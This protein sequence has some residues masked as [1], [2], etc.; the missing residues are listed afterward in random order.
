MRLHRSEFEAAIRPQVEETVDALRNA[1]ASAGLVPAQ[2]SA[3]LLV[4]G[5]SRI[6]LVG[7]L[8][9]EQLGRPVAV[10]A[11]PKNAIAMGAVLSLTQMGTSGNGPMAPQV[12]APR[13]GGSA[14]F[15]VTAAAPPFGAAPFGT[16]AGAQMSSGMP[17]VPGQQGGVGYGPSATGT[18]RPGTYDSGPTSVAAPPT[19]RLGGASGARAGVLPPPPPPRPGYG[20]PEYGGDPYEYDHVPKPA[21]GGRSPALA[22][23]RRGRRGGG[24]RDRR[25]VP[26]A[27]ELAGAGRRGHTAG[28]PGSPVA[29]GAATEPGLDGRSVRPGDDAGEP[30]G[31]RAAHAAGGPAGDHGPAADHDTAACGHDDPADGDHDRLHRRRRPYPH[32][33]ADATAARRRSRQCSSKARLPRVRASPPSPRRSDS[34]PRTPVPLDA[35]PA[36]F[37]LRVVSADTKNPVPANR[38]GIS[39]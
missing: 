32:A 34:P 14:R 6:P 11:D 21:R 31:T 7:Q 37:V 38:N 22:G 36:F 26:V 18:H 23:E 39:L 24:G 19:Q 2:L 9:S 20:E 4:G 35:V 5:S 13:V 12:P 8:V 28:Q 29:G 15:P 33:G 1:I 17:P 30:S 25:G 3:V 27:V 16:A 10:D